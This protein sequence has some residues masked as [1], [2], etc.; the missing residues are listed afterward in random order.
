MLPDVKTIL[1]AS[2]IEEGSRPAF[3]AA[4]S[5]AGHY[6]AT[7]TFLHVIE[8]LSATARS[9]LKTM[10]N[11][12]DLN[13]MHDSSVINLKNKLIS[14]IESFCET[15]LDATEAMKEGQII[16]RVEEGVADRVILKVA[17]EIGADLIVM[18]TRTHSSVGQ[19][20][21]GSTANR[22]MHHTQK[23]VLV[24]PLK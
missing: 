22:V 20:L 23:P 10:M 21:L 13:E 9:I 5:M 3:R 11:D 7:I 2:D 17:N 18:G 15:E 6:D 19:F 14:R 1:Y 12:A 24:I 8:P 4:V 16:P